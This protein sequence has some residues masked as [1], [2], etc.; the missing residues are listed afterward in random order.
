M[1]P[2]T[3]FTLIRLNENL[4]LASMIYSL[5]N[6]EGLK[7]IQRKHDRF[8]ATLVKTLFIDYI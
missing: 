5:V 2:I 8:D 3:I 1:S 4:T 6:Y 7:P